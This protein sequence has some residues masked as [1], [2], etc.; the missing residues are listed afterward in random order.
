MPVRSTT[1]PTGRTFI[2]RDAAVRV[3]R[4][5]SAPLSEI[6]LSPMTADDL[7]C[8]WRATLVRP[9]LVARV[10]HRLL[11][12]TGV[13]VDDRHDRQPRLSPHRLRIRINHL[14]SGR[15]RRGCLR[16]RLVRAA[17]LPGWGCGCS[18]VSVRF[19]VRRPGWRRRGRGGRPVRDRRR[20]SP[21]SMRRRSGGAPTGRG[22]RRGRVAGRVR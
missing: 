14:S 15:C 11:A 20:S 10:G 9:R 1:A 21:G 6:R 4:P 22:T 19:R 16:V 3:P 12:L 17:G 18:R 5:D 2:T 7:V 8:R 13:G